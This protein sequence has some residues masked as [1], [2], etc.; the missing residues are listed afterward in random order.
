M[1]Y[2]INEITNEHID[3]ILNERLPLKYWE[4]QLGVALKYEGVKPGISFSAPYPELGLLFWSALKYEV[5]DLLCN[6]EEQ[7]PREW[8]NDLITGDIRNL[9]VGISAAITSKYEISIGIGLPAAALIFKSGIIAYCSKRPKRKPFR[10]VRELLASKDK[11]V[12]EWEEDKKRKKKF[13]KKKGKK[14]TKKKSA[15]RKN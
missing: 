6:S 2:Q 10:T 12:R 1:S 11:S 9:I 14:E 4:F 7:A 5:Y 8:L 15:K 13:Q 3:Q